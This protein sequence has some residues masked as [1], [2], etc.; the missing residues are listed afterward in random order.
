MARLADV[1]M[2]FASPEW[3]DFLRKLLLARAALVPVP[4]RVTCE[5]YR[6]VPRHLSADGTLAWTRRVDGAN[7]TVTFDEAADTDAQVKLAGDYGALAD[8]CRKV[9]GDEPDMFEAL[10]ADAIAAG[11]VELLRNERDPDEPRDFTIH[12]ILAVLTR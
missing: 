7:V 8:L 4:V 9:V 6:D 2:E 1:Q 12:D 5:V 10:F 3:L 11:W